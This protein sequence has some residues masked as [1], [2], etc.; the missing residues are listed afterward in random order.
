[1]SQA[2]KRMY[3]FAKLVVCGCLALLPP[4][5]LGV[6]DPP[7]AR[8]A[9]LVQ[10][11]TR[12]HG[13]GWTVRLTEDGKRITAVIGLGSRSYG[14]QPEAAARAFLMEDATLFGLRRDLADLRVLSKHASGSGGHVEFQQVVN[15]LPVD[16]GR[17]QV[18]LSKDGRILQVINNYAALAPTGPTAPALSKEQAIDAGIAEFLRTTPPLPPDIRKKGRVEFTPVPRSELQI[19]EQPRVEDV[20]FAV[21]GHPVRAFK[22]VISAS[23]PFGYK[24]FIVD[25][26]SGRI[27][28]TKDRDQYA[29][30]TGTGQVFIPN[31]VAS[32]NNNA[33]THTTVPNTNPNPY[34]TVQL[35]DLNDPAAGPYG[36]SGPFASVQDIES[37]SNTPVSVTGSPNF[38]FQSSSDNFGDTMVYY[39]LDRI[40]RYIQE[41]GFIDVNNRSVSVDSRGLVDVCNAHYSPSPVGAGYLAFGLCS[42]SERVAEDAEVI[43]HEYGHSLQDNVTNG[44]YPSSGTP[45]SMGEG[46]GD[47]WGISNYAAE[48]TAAGHDL[49]CIGDW[50]GDGACSRRLD[51][52]LTMDDYAPLG[53][54][55]TNGQI[56]SQALFNLFNV[57]GKTTTDRIVLQSHFNVP[58]N[59]TF[60]Q[61]GDAML[62]ADLQIFSGAHLAQLCQEFMNRKIYVAGDCPVLPPSTGAQSTLV[63]IASFSEAGLP[64][65]SLAQANTI[66]SNMNSYLAEV[67]MGQA[68]LG[69]PA[70]R[71]V[72]LANARAHYYDETSHNMLV[73]MVQEVINLIH[74][75]EPGFD[76][77]AVDRLFIVTNDDG[78]GGVTGGQKEWATTG[79][80]PYSIPTGAGTKR[81][82]ASIHAF[83]QTRGQFDH[84]LGHHFGMFDLYPYDGIVFP[85]P[86]A[87]GWS[88]MA[89]AP[90]GSFSDVHFLGW[91]KAKPSWLQG[92]NITFIPRPPAD[93]DPNHRFEHTFP[94]YREETAT[95]NPVII[96]IGT[97]PNISQRLNERVSY[98][99]EAR[100]K[101]V[102]TFDSAIPSDAVLVYY[103]NEDI[104]QGFGPLRII[105]AVP[106]TSTVA[107]AILDPIDAFVGALSLLHSVHEVAFVDSL[108][109]RQ[110]PCIAHP[111]PLPWNF[112]CSLKP[113]V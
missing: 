32:L 47:Y 103:V 90:D 76:F 67:S 80:W 36:L 109:L 42:G 50:I 78:S 22:V 92:G 87:D 11:F 96:Q 100:K 73:D 33:I 41:L 58:D 108:R 4:V 99:V 29:G 37:P 40:Q 8:S 88:N 2:P 56:W 21:D 63:V 52:G 39:H 14:E 105:D 16:N 51:T 101:S 110:S 26:Q 55:H 81:F 54:V 59:V 89:K 70:F 23:R 34:Y 35:P 79:P 31:P 94:I 49:A 98:Y 6:D 19:K 77:T 27:L 71:S 9:S 10:Q 74:A 95:G 97:T 12:N 24:E 48:L 5:A 106:G 20:E 104:G 7:A 28:Q 25:A 38:V 17:V 111:I 57:L 68:T 84:A 65:V 66:A 83:N 45:G 72:N 107:A 46:F 1:M 112:S 85:R 30:V 53:D 44:K 69:T 102:G 75:A 18:N 60:K 113:P 43:G 61:A 86:Y 91:D 64:V 3:A 62:T 82:S 15:G 93:P 13:A